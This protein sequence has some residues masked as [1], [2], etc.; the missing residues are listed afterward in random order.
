MVVGVGGSCGSKWK[1]VG[2][3]G[4]ESCRVWWTGLSLASLGLFTSGGSLVRGTD[5][6]DAWR[7]KRKKRATRRYLYLTVT[8]GKL[9]VSHGPLPC[10]I[11]DVLEFVSL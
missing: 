5:V 4:V 3:E 8:P 11:K 10:S 6:V 9:Q 1:L 7:G 2:C